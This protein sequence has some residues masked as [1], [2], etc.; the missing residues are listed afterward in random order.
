MDGLQFGSVA[1]VIQAQVPKLELRLVGEISVDS[2][3]ACA[4]DEK[5]LARTRRP[6]KHRR[7][8]NLSEKD[9]A[10]KVGG[11][12]Q[13]VVAAME[14]QGNEAWEE[15]GEG[16]G[17]RKTICKSNKYWKRGEEALRCEAVGSVNIWN[18]GQQNNARTAKNDQASN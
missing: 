13:E 7:P 14:G 12:A 16:G 17:G 10:E 18:L 2:S 5:R 11:E 8:W 15:K 6:S 1:R 9:H 4:C 3:G